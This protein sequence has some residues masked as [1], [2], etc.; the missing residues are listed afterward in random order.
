MARN[1]EKSQS[2]LNRYLQMKN[3]EAG[4]INQPKEKRPFLASQENNL[5]K[6]ERWRRQVTGEIITKIS[7]IQ[8][9]INNI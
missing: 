2:M 7:E 6:A 9:G 1:E 4:G 3:K 5:S 8:N